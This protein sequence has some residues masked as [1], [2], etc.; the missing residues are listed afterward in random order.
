[1]FVLAEPTQIGRPAVNDNWIVASVLAAAI[2]CS[3]ALPLCVLFGYRAISGK[4][5]LSRAISLALILSLCS[6]SSFFGL[7]LAIRPD[8]DALE[9]DLI[10]KVIAYTIVLPV[11]GF[12]IA[13]VSLF[14]GIGM[15]L[16]YLFGGAILSLNRVIILFFASWIVEF[17]FL[18]VA[19]SSD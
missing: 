12:V 6:W 9:A 19:F 18:Y 4:I 7:F 3:I 13:P 8:A 16:V 10:E 11:F 15:L 17:L 2:V 14:F 1:M 5:E